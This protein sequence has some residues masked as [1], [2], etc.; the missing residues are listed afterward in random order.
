MNLK[1]MHITSMILATPSIRTELGQL[2]MA[3]E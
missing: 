2:A 3:H 1:S